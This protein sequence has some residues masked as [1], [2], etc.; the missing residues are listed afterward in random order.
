[1]NGAT[2]TPMVPATTLTAPPPSGRRPARPCS[3]PAPT[4]CK[5]SARR[6]R[7]AVSM[8]LARRVA[9]SAMLVS[10][11]E[12]GVAPGHHAVTAA[13]RGRQGGGVRSRWEHAGVNRGAVGG[14]GVKAV[15][16]I[17]ELD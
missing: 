14:Q 12:S 17:V 4:T 6:T 13:R 7:G 5:V 3:G 16:L 11:S 2:D 9:Y 10:L 1:M 8:P 15:S